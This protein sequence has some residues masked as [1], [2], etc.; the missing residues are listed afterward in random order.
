MISEIAGL[1]GR[2]DR[3]ITRGLGRGL[4]KGG[5]HRSQEQQP[6]READVAR[7]GCERSS[8][9]QGRLTS[10]AGA[11]ARRGDS[12]PRAHPLAA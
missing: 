6:A 8:N 3:L 7:R 10:L 1:L 9:P 12:R 4:G 11:A 5:R 2:S